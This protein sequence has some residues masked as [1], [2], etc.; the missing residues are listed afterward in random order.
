[1]IS[2]W[3]PRPKNYSGRLKRGSESFTFRAS[4]IDMDGLGFDLGVEKTWG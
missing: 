2:S 1:M 4:F 3:Q